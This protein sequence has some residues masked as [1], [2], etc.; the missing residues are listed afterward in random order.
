MSTEKVLEQA[1]ID[2]LIRG[3]NT[4]AVDT[5]PPAAPGEVRSFDFGRQ[6]PVLHGRMPT[7]EVINERFVRLTRVSFGELL[8]RTCEVTVAP[9]QIIR[10]GE[11]LAKLGTPSSLNVVKMNPLRGTALLVLD[12]QLVFAVVDNFFGGSGRQAHI[13]GREFTATEQ[14]I[15]HMILRNVFADLREA[16]SQVVSIELEYLHSESNPQ[17]VGIVPSAEFVVVMP[18]RVGLDAS[19][20]ELQLALPYA[21]IE[22]LQEVLD[23][24]SAERPGADERWAAALREEIAEAEVELKT[25][26]G[27]TC[28]TLADLLNLKSGDVLPCDFA[29]KVTLLAEDLPLFRGSFG[30]SRGQQAIKVEERMR[31]SKPLALEPTN[32]KS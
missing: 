12:P 21:M 23:A 17:F 30:W 9:V 20:G 32:L 16:W 29:G 31:R 4:G 18:C 2:A 15:I 11:Y 5:Q 22:P 6:L 24:G 13:E 27:N 28:L 7:L 10:C 1:E 8:R 19:G 25:V 14:R 3:V 26:L